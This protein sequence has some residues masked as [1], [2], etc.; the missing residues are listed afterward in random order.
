MDSAQIVIVED[1]QEISELIQLQ[2]KI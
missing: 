1:E 2:Q